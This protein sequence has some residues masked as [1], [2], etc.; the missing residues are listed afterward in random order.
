MN[1][2]WRR[3][4]ELGSSA[5]WT[6][7]SCLRPLRW[8]ANFVTVTT[9][10]AAAFFRLHSRNDFALQL[11]SP[12]LVVTQGLA[13]SLKVQV[14]ALGTFKQAVTLSAENLPAG[15]TAVSIPPRCRTASILTLIAD[16]SVGASNYP[17]TIVG[18]GA[19]SSHAVPLNLTVSA[20]AL[21]TPPS[22][23]NTVPT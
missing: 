22:G 11:D 8:P 13:N 5:Q 15:L 2:F 7:N 3:P 9:S 18:Q 6:T 19:L 1:I 14:T 10:G 12:A 23:L 16:A 20:E 21:S 17:V 4:G